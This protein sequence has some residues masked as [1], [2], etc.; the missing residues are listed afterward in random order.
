VHADDPDFTFCTMHDVLRTMHTPAF[1]ALEAQ[2]A[3][4][5]DGPPPVNPE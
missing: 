2:L 3:A 4:L 5:G 1:D